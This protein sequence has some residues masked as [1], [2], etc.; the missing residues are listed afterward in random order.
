[1]KNKVQERLNE[2]LVEK[3]ITAY[4]LSKDLNI[5][6]SVLHYWL[7]GKTAPNCDYLINLAIY[8]E[9]TADYILGLE[10][11]TGAKYVNSFNNTIVNASE[12][13]TIKF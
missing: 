8:F 11:E 2:L 9:V 13:S 4:K 7:T 1:M 3:G 12:N 10:D 6:K 5:S